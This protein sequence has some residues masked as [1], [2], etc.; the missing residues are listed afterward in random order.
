[1]R[2]KRKHSRLAFVAAAAAFALF[3]AACGGGGNDDVASSGEGVTIGVSFYDNKVIP[4]YVDIE[5]GM[6]ETA[7][8][9]GA[10]ISFSYANFD[11]A[12]QVQQIEQF[13]VQGV[14]IIL[15]TPLDRN[16]LLT[17]YEAARE[18][19]IP[20]ISFANKVDDKNE[21]LFVGRDWAEMG[22]LM[23]EAIARHL[24]G[25][26]Q[27][28]VIAG[29]PQID[30]VRQVSEGWRRVLD[31]NPGLKLVSELTTPDMSREDGLNLAKTLLA[32]NPDVDGIACTIDQIC[33]GVVQAIA[34]QGLSQKDIFVAAL[35]A[36]AEAVE[37]VKT[38]TGIDFTLGMRGFTWGQQIVK[39]ALAYLVGDKPDKH[40]VESE[41]VI[42]DGKSVKALTKEDLK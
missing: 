3:V 41:F 31:E 16:A 10:E 18:A 17:A 34:E 37:Q 25:K 40:M 28:A 7:T 5:A 36:D 39:V 35:D 14:D 2:V 11:P 33:L 15:A 32:A 8:E 9:L 27:V 22:R 6:Q 13:I 38:G 21:D 20:I 24:G 23:M 42:V 26:G 4:L 12:A 1:M 30:V 19:G 29:P